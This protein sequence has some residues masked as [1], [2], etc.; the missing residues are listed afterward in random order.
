VIAGID[1]VVQHAHDPG[2]NIRVLNLSY[3]TNSA[4]PWQLDPLAYAAEQAWKHGIVVVAAAGNTGFQHGNGAPGLA[5]PAYDPYVIGVG[6]ADSQ[7]TAVKDDD[8]VAD[9]SAISGCGRCKAPDFVAPGAHLQGL[10][11][12]DSWLDVNHPEGRVD[13]RY[14]RGSGTSESAAITSGAVALLLQRYPELTPDDVKRFIQ[15]NARKLLGSGPRSQGAGAIELGAMG[16]PPAHAD[17]IQSFE[18]STGAGSLEASRGTDHLTRD[19]VVLA[20]E[21]DVVGTP[22]DTAAL[23][24]AEADGSSWSGGVWNGSSWSGSSWSGSSW[25]GSSWSGSS[26]SGSSWSGSSWSDAFWG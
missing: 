15:A 23:A 25:S 11:V 21:Q 2:L 7:G 14:V 16:A 12:G 19:G 18:N 17:A 13:E 10:R 26:W 6:A 5:D 9:F 3:G 8:R 24:A 4:Q 1:W 20:G 22:V